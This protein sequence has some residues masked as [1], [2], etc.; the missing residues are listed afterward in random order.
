MQTE[1]IDW[2][3]GSPDDFCSDGILYIDGSATDPTAP[4]LSR[5]GFA[6]AALDRQA[7]LTALARGSP[8]ELGHSTLR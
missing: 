6:N 7:E 5:L 4:E 1:S 8:P 2:L 3:I